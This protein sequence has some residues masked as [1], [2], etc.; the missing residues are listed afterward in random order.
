MIIRKGIIFKMRSTYFIRINIASQ[1]FPDVIV[2]I[3]LINF[4]TGNN[5]LGIQTE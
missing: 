2:A 5:Y 1:V 4:V 3:N